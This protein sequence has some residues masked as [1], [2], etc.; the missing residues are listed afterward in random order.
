MSTVDSQLLVCAS[1]VTHDLG[2]RPRTERGML[3]L[4]RATVLGIGAAATATAMVL[5]KNVFD[6]VLFAWAALGSAFGPLLLVR[7]V[8]GAVH[9]TY[10]LAAIGVG[11]LGAIGGFYAPLVQKGF[12]DRVLSWLVALAIAAL[13]AR[14]AKRVVG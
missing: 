12:D 1:S 4:A 2:L 10:A 6:N 3:L 8:A 5:P 11:G 7:L 13:G 14:A 9:P